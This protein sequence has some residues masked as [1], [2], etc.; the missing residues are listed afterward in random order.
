L[1]IAPCR[2]HN[3]N[4]QY[5][6]RNLRKVSRY[7][8]HELHFGHAALGSNRG[9]IRSPRSEFLGVEEWFFGRP[10]GM[11]NT[12]QRIKNAVSTP[13][14]SLFSWLWP[15]P[16]ESLLSTASKI[17]V[18][19]P[20]APSLVLSHRMNPGGPSQVC[21]RGPPM[22]SLPMASSACPRRTK[23]SRS[24]YPTS[25]IAFSL[26]GTSARWLCRRAAR[27]PFINFVAVFSLARACG[28]NRLDATF[29]RAVR[30][31]DS[32][33]RKQKAGRKLLRYV[34]NRVWFVPSH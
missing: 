15:T 2:A 11:H 25:A 16:R 22:N 29:G 28:I 30:A 7:C 31:S 18:Q 34:I 8:M 27:P 10:C 1:S 33:R 5:V 6:C 19:C 13:A 14:S 12:L 17:A 23:G 24:V 21:E 20:S 9:L 32:K 3:V 26:S 4:T